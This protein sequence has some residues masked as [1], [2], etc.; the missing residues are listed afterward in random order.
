MNLTQLCQSLL[1]VALGMSSSLATAV[2]NGRDA[3]HSSAEPS[4]PVVG[5][6]MSEAQPDGSTRYYKGTAFLIG[7]NLLLT[8]G[9]NVAYIPDPSNIEAIFASVPCWGPNVCHERR[10][11]AMKAVVHRLFR[12]ISG[13]TEFDLAVVKLATTAPDDYRAIPIINKSISLG[14]VQL[15]F[16]GFGTDREASNT[17]LSAF[18][19]RSVNLTTINP[20][21][22]LG[23]KQNF[24]IDQ[25][26]GG[27]CGGD[28]GGP[29][30]VKSP[31]FE[32]IGIA[33][34]TTYSDG[35][36]HCLTKSAFTDLVFFREWIRRT[37]KQL[38]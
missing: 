23:S 15:Q 11:A 34:H 9:H 30:I 29:A 22:R 8:A 32:A 36:E 7:P 35:V 5:L 17:P 18:R 33:I 2:I 25:S 37:V 20:D 31:S 10:I 24:W 16:F 3:E 6:Q 4:A 38:Q 1:V 13:G 12:Q 28:S 26:R 14:A 21:Y 27:I 19:L